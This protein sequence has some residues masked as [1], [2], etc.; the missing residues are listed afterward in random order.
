MDLLG[1]KLKIMKEL[2]TRTYKDLSSLSILWTSQTQ[3]DKNKILMQDQHYFALTVCLLC[4]SEIV[5]QAQDYIGC[6]YGPKLAS[7]QYIRLIWQ[8]PNLPHN[9]HCN[10][11]GKRHNLICL[12][13]CPSANVLSN[14]ISPHLTSS[15]ASYTIK[16]DKA[17]VSAS[18]QGDGNAI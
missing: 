16:L 2:L 3:C 17:L 15:L 11:N 13:I 14:Q 8:T 12:H 10:Q 18:E 7:L 6:K 1:S 9:L 5:M 4:W